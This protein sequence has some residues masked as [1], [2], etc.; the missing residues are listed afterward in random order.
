MECFLSF[1][2]ELDLYIV[3]NEQLLRPYVKVMVRDSTQELC[4]FLCFA[5]VVED[6]PFADYLEVGGESAFL[7]TRDGNDSDLV[8]LLDGAGNSE[9]WEFEFLAVLNEEVEVVD[10]SDLTWNRDSFGVVGP[11]LA[12]VD[13]GFVRAFAE[14]RVH[15]VATDHHSSAT[16]SSFA[17]DSCDILLIGE[18]ELLHI[19]A[20]AKHHVEWRRVVVFEHIL[21]RALLKEVIF[22]ALLA[23][24][25]VHF[26]VIVILLVEKALHVDH[27]VAVHGFEANRGKSH[28]DH[29]RQDV[30]QI[31]VEPF[32]HVP[33]LVFGDKSFDNVPGLLRHLPTFL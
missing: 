13:E 7:E 27:G 16:L 26:V 3:I 12:V 31:E 9:V 8:D 20:E 25:I 18:Q 10:V 2:V 24:E 4:L 29:V 11:Y 1:L 32:V 19:G 33:F 15:Q 23:T 21:L 5:V 14:L 6:V 28:R 22:V 17:M 30:R